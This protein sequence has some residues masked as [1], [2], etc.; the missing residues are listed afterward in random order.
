MSASAALFPRVFTRL[1]ALYL[2]ACASRPPASSAPSIDSQSRLADV[3]LDSS[4]RD[5]TTDDAVPARNEARAT[6]GTDDAAQDGGT[7]TPRC[8]AR[9]RAAFHLR[10]RDEVA[11]MGPE[12]PAGTT[13]DVLGVT[14]F[15]RERTNG[16]TA[17]VLTRVRVLSDGATGYAF[18]RPVEFAQDCPVVAASPSML[19]ALRGGSATRA[20]ERMPRVYPSRAA[21]MGRALGVSLVRRIDV[22]GDGSVDELL[23]VLASDTDGRLMRSIRLLRRGAEG[24]TVD[25]LVAYPDRDCGEAGS[26]RLVSV[27][28]TRPAP[29]LVFFAYGC[30]EPT[31]GP[32]APL[33]G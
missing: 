30:R 10:P 15:A 5:E 33:H 17:S 25:S 19:A 8:T 31:P 28:A 12:Y 21:A 9:M 16:E 4:A 1:A 2:T 20:E 24:F 27:L 11:T 14:V 29:S 22:D 7:R 13:L 32:H 3:S 18:V 26:T 23:G 6:F